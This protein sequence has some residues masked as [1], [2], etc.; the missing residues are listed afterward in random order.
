MPPPPHLHA[1]APCHVRHDVIGGLFL[2]L[3]QDGEQRLDRGLQPAHGVEMGAHMMVHHRQMSEHALV[4][5]MIR[6]GRVHLRADLGGLLRRRAIGVGERVPRRLLRV[7]E[8]Q[9]RLEIG[10]P[11]F[12]MLGHAAEHVPHHAG[13]AA[14]VLHA[15]HAAMPP[16]CSIPLHA[17]HV[18]ALHVMAHRAMVHAPGGRWRAL[19]GLGQGDPGH[20]EKRRRPRDVAARQ[21]FA[22]GLFM[23]IHGDLPLG[24]FVRAFRL[25]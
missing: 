21:D 6:A 22:N 4:H 7:R 17:L 9:F 16:P 3:G 11:A 25:W 24:A 18:H 14:A 20:Q 5:G 2:L 15:A 19:R 13:H 23:R 10:E 1:N 12:D 8:F